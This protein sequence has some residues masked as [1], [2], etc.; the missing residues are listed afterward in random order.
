MGWFKFVKVAFQLINTVVQWANRNSLITLGQQQELAR[1][2][3]AFLRSAGV[4][5]RIIAEIV[6]ATPEEI[7]AKLEDRFVD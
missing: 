4:T 7:D 2:S 6:T 5:D 1:Q 3:V